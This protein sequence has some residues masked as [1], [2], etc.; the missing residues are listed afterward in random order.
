MNSING[1]QLEQNE[2]SINLL[3]QQIMSEHETE[4]LQRIEAIHAK[5]KKTSRNVIIVIKIAVGII[6][7]I[8][9]I[10][11]VQGFATSRESSKA[12]TALKSVSDTQTLMYEVFN[13]QISD[14]KAKASEDKTELKNNIETSKSELQRQLD[15]IMKDRK[16]TERGSMR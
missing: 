3:I 12:V 11:I 1:K 2:K 7:T 6:V 9:G 16:L 5:M 14:I 4:F 15:L 13:T 10:V 8:G